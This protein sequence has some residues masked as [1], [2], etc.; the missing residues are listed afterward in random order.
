VLVLTY[1][2]SRNNSNCFNPLPG[3]TDDV[4]PENLACDHDARDVTSALTD[5]V[6]LGIAKVTFNWKIPEIPVAAQDLDRAAARAQRSLHH[7]ILGHAGFQFDRHGGGVCAR[8]I[9]REQPRRFDFGR[10]FGGRRLNR[11]ERA[12]R[13]AEP[14]AFARIGYYRVKHR[15]PQTY[16]ECDDVDV[17]AVG[18]SGEGAKAIT[19]VVNQVLGGNLDLIEI[20]RR[21]GRS[22][23]AYFFVRLA[24]L[25]SFHPALKYESGPPCS[26]RAVITKMSAI[27]PLVLNA[28]DPLIR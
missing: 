6:H 23:N 14:S 4:A 28:S 25:E 3:K 26:V 13:L 9:E 19:L 20:K 8:A 10:H 7:K 5:L 22:V 12:D 24:D 17:A 2:R 1:P 15:L 18:C 11:M 21:S 16:R 27:Q